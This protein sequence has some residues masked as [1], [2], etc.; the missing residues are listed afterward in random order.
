MPRVIKKKIYQDL[1]LI[2]DHLMKKVR[3]DYWADYIYNLTFEY[4]NNNPRILELGSGNCQFAEYFIKK[5]PNYVATDISIDM[6]RR[7]K[8]KLINVCCD[9]TSLPFNSKFDMILS[10]FDSV[11]YLTSKKKLL[12]FLNESASLLKENG[13]LTFDAS[14]E[15]NSLKHIN[16]PV[17]QGKIKDI[18]Y[19]HR[20]IYD[21][22]S[23]IH[24]NIFEIKFAD[25][26]THK[27]THKQKIFHFVDY[28]NYIEKAK[29]YV[30]DCVEAF[31]FRKG[32]ENSKRVQFIV[33]KA[34]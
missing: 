12:L 28:F 5:F 7:S 31:T 25:G 24:S 21:K 17:R 26:N 20:S 1:S 13:I 10:T 16:N 27:E 33:K 22:S 9:M 8:T 11:N 18:E 4:L 23:R 15:G 30:V 2:Y 14:M 6:L 19:V 34:G 3:Y 32:K 29:L